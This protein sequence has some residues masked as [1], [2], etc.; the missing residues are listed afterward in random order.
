M[1]QDQITNIAFA[2]ILV[3]ILYLIYRRTQTKPEKQSDKML[4]ELY[5]IKDALI[6]KKYIE[7]YRS[8]GNNGL[9]II[10]T[11]MEQMVDIMIAILKQNPTR[12]MV[13]SFVRE[14][15][16]ATTIA[17]AME[18]VGKEIVK[19]I[20]QNDMLE[21]KEV[22]SRSINKNGETLEE[23]TRT[24]YIPKQESVI[25]IASATKDG[26]LKVLKDE[27][28]YDKYYEAVTNIILDVERKTNP[29]ATD[30]R[31]PSNEVFKTEI[32]PRLITSVGDMFDRRFSSNRRVQERAPPPP[33]VEGSQKMSTRPF[34]V[35]LYDKAGC[36]GEV[37]RAVQ[38]SAG[39][40]LEK[41]FNVKSKEGSKK[42]CCMKVSNANITFDENTWAKN[43]KGEHVKMRIPSNRI[44]EEQKIELNG[45]SSNYSFRM[46][47]LI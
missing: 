28:K 4:R 30:E 46:S 26:T 3:A 37:V 9:T 22:T 35:E 21:K 44:S 13:D 34:K 47:P 27:S 43:D 25:A 19:A 24:I 20:S 15:A 8:D 6:P 42:A 7:K 29:G 23:Q 39:T 2:L 10:G 11:A 32:M 31:F 16:D 12:E 14:A 40:P 17:E 5:S 18:V 38:A 1:K 33:P 41:V 36:T 45:C